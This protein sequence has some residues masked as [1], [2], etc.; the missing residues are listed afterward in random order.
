MNFNRGFLEKL[1]GTK[2]GTIEELDELYVEMTE[3][4]DDMV[5]E[6]TATH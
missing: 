2:C 4:K 3:R 5:R 6:I 1:A